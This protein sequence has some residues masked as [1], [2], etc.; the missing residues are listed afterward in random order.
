MPR[1][2]STHV[3]D[4]SAVGRRLREARAAAG[5]SQRELAFDGCSPAYI[6]R[7]ESGHRIPSL[8]LIRELA[9]RLGVS[10]EHLARGRAGSVP[11]GEAEMALRLDESER[12]GELFRKALEDS[13]T[14]EGRSR[15]LEG[16]GHLA[17]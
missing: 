11:L 2:K 17:F 16:L 15:A 4:S 13:E 8:Q 3:D 1:V 10:E 5:L 7:I 9:R 12:A 6:S 14:P